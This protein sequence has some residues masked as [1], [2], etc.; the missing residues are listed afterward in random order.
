MTAQIDIERAE[1]RRRRL[2]H[3]HGESLGPEGVRLFASSSVELEVFGLDVA[4]GDLLGCWW[5]PLTI[6]RNGL[7]LV[8]SGCLWG[9]ISLS[10][11]AFSLREPLC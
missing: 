11:G 7:C 1:E 9:G 3:G 2:E 8:P 10:S 5:V 4:M 6:A